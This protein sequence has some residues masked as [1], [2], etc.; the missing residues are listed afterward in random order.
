MILNIDFVSL[1]SCLACWISLEFL[2][3]QIPVSTLIYI[4][5]VETAPVQ[6]YCVYFLYCWLTSYLHAV[7]DVTWFHEHSLNAHYFRR[8]WIMEW[9]SEPF[10]L[11][12]WKMPLYWREGTNS[13][14]EKKKGWFVLGSFKNSNNIIPMDPSPTTHA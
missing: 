13:V 14:S 12:R 10:S 5:T 4:W 8:D 7:I 11:E 3:F 2:L 1:S 6:H 9:W